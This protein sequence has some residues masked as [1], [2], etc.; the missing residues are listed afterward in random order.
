MSSGEAYRLCVLGG[1]F[2]KQKKKLEPQN[3]S[4]FSFY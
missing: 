2:K 4:F 1:T 3:F